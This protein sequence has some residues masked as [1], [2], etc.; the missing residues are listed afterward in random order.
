MA[1]KDSIHIA[2]GSK[3]K[4]NSNVKL[5]PG[6]PFYNKSQ[7]YLTIGKDDDDSSIANQPIRVREL[8]GNSGEDATVG[9]HDTTDDTFYVKHINSDSNNRLEIK[10]AEKVVIEGGSGSSIVVDDANGLQVN[11]VKKSNTATKPLFIEGEV[12][13][14]TTKTIGSETKPIWVRGGEIVET[15]TSVGDKYT[16]VYLNNGEIKQCESMYSYYEPIYLIDKEK[17]ISYRISANSTIHIP[18][19][20]INT[21]LLPK[22]NKNPL[23][24]HY[25]CLFIGN[26]SGDSHV[27]SCILPLDVF[28]WEITPSSGVRG[29]INAGADYCEFRLKSD[30]DGGVNVMFGSAGSAFR[31]EKF[32]IYLFGKKP[33]IQK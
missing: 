9:G 30:G 22:G 19:S 8:G 24:L 7:N 5:A 23:S 6:Q 26:Y 17:D 2:R 12:V 4:I 32:Y 20:S 33:I 11:G 31:G 3:G 29:V 13:K 18:E 25:F 28:E 14:T 27:S 1:G 10:D 21:D 15:S 16:P